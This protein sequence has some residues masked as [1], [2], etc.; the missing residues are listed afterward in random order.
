MGSIPGKVSELLNSSF[1][2][3]GLIISSFNFH[4]SHHDA[5]SVGTMDF[6]REWK[7]MQ[8]ERSVGGISSLNVN[9]AAGQGEME[10]KINNIVFMCVLL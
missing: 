6:K 9:K 5:G 3:S 7:R 8:Q 2:V 10:R 4:V 1:G